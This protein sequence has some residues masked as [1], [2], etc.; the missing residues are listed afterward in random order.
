MRSKCLLLRAIYW[1]LNIFFGN[2]SHTF[3]Q[4]RMLNSP[5]NA[6]LLV[7]AN[8]VLTAMILHCEGVTCWNFMQIP[9]VPPF[10]HTQAWPTS[11]N[12]WCSNKDENPFLASNLQTRI[13]LFVDQ[14][15]KPVVLLPGIETLGFCGVRWELHSR[16]T[17]APLT[18]V[19]TLITALQCS[20]QPLAAQHCC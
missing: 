15:T 8:C 20:Q 2:V 10:T 4:L 19:L 5:C 1:Y 14:M 9:Q 3:C 11:R 13:I 16:P 17:C 7:T 18:N 12:Q 6:V